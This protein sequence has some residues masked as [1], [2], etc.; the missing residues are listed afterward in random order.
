MLTSNLPLLL[1][2]AVVIVVVVAY[3]RDL[4]GW[5]APVLTVGRALF[6]LWVVFTL[7]WSAWIYLEA[8]H[9]YPWC[10]LQDRWLL[11]IVAV[12]VPAVLFAVGWLVLWTVRTVRVRRR[13]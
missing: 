10:D 6:W 5:L 4:Y 3:R 9:C 1:P 8:T 2:V 7:L 12:A 11:I 13:S